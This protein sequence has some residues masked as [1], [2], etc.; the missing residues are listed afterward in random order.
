LRSVHWHRQRPNCAV[1]FKPNLIWV[2]AFGCARFTYPP[3]RDAAQPFLN[4]PSAT[5]HITGIL[6]NGFSVGAGNLANENT[7]TYRYATWMNNVVPATP[8]LDSPADTATNQSLTPALLTTATDTSSDYLRYKIELCTNV[9]MTTGCQT[10]D[11]TSSQTGWS[12]QNAQ[13]STAYTS[14]TQATYT[15][16]SALAGNTTYYWR[17][18]AIDPGGV[19]T[20]SGTQTPRSFTTLNPGSSPATPSL[21]SPTDTATGQSLTPALLTTTTD[22]DS[23]YLR[24]KIELCTNVGMSVGCSTF[25]QTSSQTGWSGQNAQTSTA[26]SSGTQATYT[27]QSALSPT[28]TYYWRSYAIDPAGTNTW[29]STQGTP[30]S[31]TTQNPAPVPES[32]ECRIDESNDK[33]TFIVSWFDRATDED[34]Y[35]TAES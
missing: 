9:G 22:A 15:V 18:Y 3:R 30:Y 19:N 31:F 17:S 35:E 6:S 11:Q 16:Q 28:T 12:G 21:D 32:L 2:K 8:S 20:W 26:Y 24:Y 33:N 1:G 10:F 5:T 14:G 25:D 23:D 27:I 7:F 4:S 13:T 29:S 34:G